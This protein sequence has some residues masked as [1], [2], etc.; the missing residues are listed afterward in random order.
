M[1]IVQGRGKDVRV[2]DRH[3]VEER[4]RAARGD[5]FD[6]VERVA[7]EVTRPVEPRLPVEAGR[8]DH[9]RVVFPVSVRPPHP[10]VGRRVNMVVDVDGPNRARILMH[11]HD[12]LLALD[13]LHRKRHV[14]PTRHTREVAFD[15]R[16]ELNRARAVLVPLRQR[17]RP[18]GNLVAFHHAETAR[19]R[20]QRTELSHHARSRRVR[21]DVP[22][23]RVER[24]PDPVQ[25]G[26]PIRR[27]RRPILSCLRG[28]RGHR[29][30]SGGRD[31]RRDRQ[32]GEPVAHQSGLH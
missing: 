17:L 12:V 5:A 2:L 26:A 29:R 24:L 30:Q 6:Q 14:H 18:I 25:V 16:I 32:K 11:D 19:Y 23:R 15:H 31:H 1:L 10:A 28:G 22:V 3:F 8:V 20:R 4:L 27:A 7:V 13:D 21:L 9:Q